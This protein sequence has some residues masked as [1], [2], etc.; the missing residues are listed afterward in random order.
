MIRTSLIVLLLLAPEHGLSAQAAPP[1]RDAPRAVD[2]APGRAQALARVDSLYWD[3]DVAASLA[4]AEALV[5]ADPDGAAAW[6]AARATVALG[7]AAEG[8]DAQNAWY[9]RGEEHAERAYAADSLSMDAL[10]WLTAN[11]GRHALQVGAREAARLGDEVWR[12]AHRMLARDPEFAGAHNVLGK[13]QYEVMTLSRVERFIAKVLLGD[14]EALRSSSWEG[15][16]RALRRAVEL[17]PDG[18]LFR[19][20]LGRL[21]IR[22]GRLDEALAELTVVA[23]LPPLYPS[24]PAF[25]EYARRILDENGVAP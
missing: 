21:L 4:E 16:E 14:N 12:L 19:N 2:V 15:A 18:V 10:F 8:N 25:I 20:D 7:M 13:V 24:D 9:R 23:S 22:T 3:F 6:H 17:A 11:K 1:P 5:D